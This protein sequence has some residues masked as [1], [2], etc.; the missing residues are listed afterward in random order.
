[1][2]MGTGAGSEEVVQLVVGAT[3]LVGRSGALEPAHR[4]IAPFDATVILLQSVVE[5]L[6]VAMPDLLAQHRPD[7]PRMTVV[8]VRG[9]PIRGNI[10]DGLGGLEECLRGGHVAVL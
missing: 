1:M 6:A 3:E 10:G 5:I 4:A 2:L 7:R 8:P 9:H